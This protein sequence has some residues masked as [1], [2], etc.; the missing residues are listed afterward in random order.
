MPP[1]PKELS[2]LDL[3]VLAWVGRFRFVT[4][5][6]VS[7][8]FG[9]SVQ[10]ARARLRRLERDGL[11]ARERANQAEEHAVYLTPLG[12]GWVGLPRR[13]PPRVHVQRDH[14]LAIAWLSTVLEREA[15]GPVLTERECRRAEVTGDCRR[16]VE[17][18]RWAGRVDR[19]RWPDLV[20]ETRDGPVAYEIEFA[21]KG[22]ARLEGIVDAY[23]QSATFTAVQ[24]YLSDP[25][26]AARLQ[27]IVDGQLARQGSAMFRSQFPVPVH[28][29]P[30][31]GAPTAQQAA[32][33]RAI[34]RARADPA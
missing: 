15:L 7:D 4:A 12:S 29:T 24:F 34:H 30:W 31:P 21:P 20:Q 1:T 17:V 32:V 19:R 25:A 14:E 3:A 9:V 16:S 28:V 6:L 11:V 22:S 33:I 26:L 10:R 27:R 2:E 8:R 13:R 18:F 5:E 23:L